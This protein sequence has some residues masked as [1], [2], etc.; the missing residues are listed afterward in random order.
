[1]S[2]TVKHVN[3]YRQGCSYSK[4]FEIAQKK[5][6]IS[7]PELIKATAEAM[8]KS[9]E[10]ATYDVRVVV[11]PS[12]EKWG[13]SS[14]R[15]G[16]Y[17]FEDCIQKVID[18]KKED[19]KIRFHW[20]KEVM[21]KVVKAGAKAKK[22]KKIAVKSEKTKAVVKAKVAKKAKAVKVAKVDVIAPVAPAPVVEIVA[23]VAIVPE[24]IA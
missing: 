8:G 18:G 6:V 10:K 15:S 1:M 22:V 12:K 19:P 2:N 17:Y 21:V 7:I 13:S 23:P 20:R 14:A 11:S 16:N 9:I 4:V 24:V 3:P 5:Q